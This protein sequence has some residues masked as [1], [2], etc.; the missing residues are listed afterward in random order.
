[1]PKDKSDP[2]DCEDQHER[3][4]HGREDQPGPVMPGPRRDGTRLVPFFEF[5][6]PI[7]GE[8]PSRVSETSPSMDVDVVL[9]LVGD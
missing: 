5:R 3:C 6:G 7:H 2:A 8:L 9:A 4:H 1:M